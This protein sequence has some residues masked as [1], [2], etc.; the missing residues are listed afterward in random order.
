ML[1]MD[2]FQKIFEFE[3]RSKLSRRCRTTNEEI[4]L[5]YNSFKFYDFESSSIIDRNRW[6]KGI[7]RTGLCG[8]NINDLSDLFSRYDKNNTGYIN[9]R[10]FT[11][12]IY[13]REELLPLSKE[14]IENTFS[15]IVEEAN[16]KQKSFP[17]IEFKP[18]GLYD[19]S[20]EIML[21]NEKKFK[22]IDNN[23]NRIHKKVE[24]EKNNKINN[25]INRTPLIRRNYS[26][27]SNLSIQ[28]YS[29]FFENEKKYK[30]FN[31]A[32]KS[33]ININNGVTYYTFMK[34][35]KKYQNQKDKTI[36]IKTCHFILRT[37]GVN[38]KFYDLIELFKSINKL[39]S[40]QINIE[41][42]LNL[43][44]GEINIKR[45]TSIENIFKM[46]DTEKIGK[47]KLEEI[48]SLYNCKMHPDA[49]I[50]FK[51]E[52]DIFKEFCYTFDIFC[53]FYHIHEYIN[54]E[55]FIEYYKGIS[56]SILDDNYFDDII[57]GVWNISIVRSRNV[58]KIINN[59]LIINH[60]ND[61]IYGEELIE[62]KINSNN[63][64]ILNNRYVNNPSKNIFTF[65]NIN[66]P[67]NIKR[68]KEEEKQNINMSSLT[69]MP[70]RP[71]C[72]FE[73]I[74]PNHIPIKTP[75]YQR[76]KMFRSFQHNPIT[77]EISINKENCKQS[78]YETY[79][80]KISYSLQ[81]LKE[82]I[83][84]RGQK[85]IFNLQKLFCLYDKEKTGQISYIKFI[86]LCEIFNIN[87]ERNNL[88]DIFDFFDR[89]KIG[90][91]KYDE[92]IQEL[93]RNISINRV[94]FI[95]NLYNDFDKD[96]YGNIFI[97]DIRKR[98]KP[99][100][101]PFVKEGN[102]SEPEIY[103]EFLECINIY[104]IYTSIVNRQ[105]NTDILNYGGFLDFF[106]EISFSV[107]DDNLFEDIL[108]NCFA[109]SKYD[110]NEIKNREDNINLRNAY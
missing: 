44:R 49:Y 9:Y 4:R 20:F 89:E 66:P 52:E 95:K 50:G 1:D 85:G 68:E 24:E 12:Y 46:I 107:K 77:N 76:N 10:N 81:K 84:S 43:I 100:N 72:K 33:Q 80:R 94:V 3:I 62:N 53:D 88:K 16:K 29:M 41:E 45:K 34:E 15:Q 22:K 60:K 71:E 82:I 90:S 31:E 79:K 67:Q 28:N 59:N 57:N 91:M 102:K 21:D 42:L 105:Y 40:N 39:N 5:L 61:E 65:K 63:N 99:Y 30:K 75:L 38:F 51:K 6:I 11:Y 97:N 17:N 23:I 92:L 58:D 19:R 93:I 2:E 83:I 32:L 96:K 8:F 106:K 36:N 55:Q 74:N 35:L 64:Y 78:Y 47:I 56:A 109:N 98:F 110:E 104:K 37:L 48:K 27:L 54:C 7:Q 25:Y 14:I 69:P 18:P 101:H 26:N 86:E 73:K 13:G 108:I 87:L 70:K 103:F